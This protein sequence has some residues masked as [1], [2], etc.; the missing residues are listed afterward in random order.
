MSSRNGIVIQCPRCLGSFLASRSV[1]RTGG[2]CAQCGVELRASPTYA[3]TLSVLSMWI[4]VVIL[5]VVRVRVLDFVLLLLPLWLMVLA[6]MVRVVPHFVPP[7]LEPPDST[8]MTTL[9]LAEPGVK[10]TRERAGH[11]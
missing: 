1:Y 7:R 8:S 9:G 6:V 3:R 4:G 10:D 2:R 11:R 5:W